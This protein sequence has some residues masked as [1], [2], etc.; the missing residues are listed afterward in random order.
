MDSQSRWAAQEGLAWLIP[1]P[2]H[3]SPAPGQR[4]LPRGLIVS[5][6]KPR[7]KPPSRSGPGG[8]QRRPPLTEPSLSL[9]PNFLARCRSTL[10][11]QALCCHL[12]LQNLQK[13]SESSRRLSCFTT[14]RSQEPLG[15]DR[16]ATAAHQRLPP[17]R[18]QPGAPSPRSPASAR[19]PSFLF[20]FF[21]I[22]ETEVV[23]SKSQGAAGERG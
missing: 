22:L 11:S 16:K 17:L 14:A 1:I 21:Y 20:F 6:Q 19:L 15:P 7:Q 5:A 23:R 9:L 8:E 13:F 18:A 12:L 2:P 10:L 3:L 4:A